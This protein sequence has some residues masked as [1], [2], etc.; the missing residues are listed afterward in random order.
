MI[1]YDISYMLYHSLRQN[2][3][4]LLLHH[5]ARFP[6]SSARFVLPSASFLIPDSY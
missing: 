4:S 3:S 1:I 5:C 6:R 2:L